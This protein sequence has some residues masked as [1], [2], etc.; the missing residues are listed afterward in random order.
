MMN[1]KLGYA[2]FW[3]TLV[4][5]FGV[6]FP[7]HFVGMAGAPRRYYDYSEFE[8]LQWVMD[9]NPIIS[10]FALIGGAAQLLFIFNFFHSI[11]HPPA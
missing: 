3:F 6:F 4:C 10:V 8:F 11:F 1:T 2:H 9:L 7:M 5:G